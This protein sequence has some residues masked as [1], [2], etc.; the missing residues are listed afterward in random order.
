MHGH[1]S[2]LAVRRAK[3][4]PK[5]RPTD[6]PTDEQTDGQA[7]LYCRV[8]ATEIATSIFLL[9]HTTEWKHPAKDESRAGEF[10]FG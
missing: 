6:Q 5:G 1:K 8:V 9:Y 3:A 7:L 10:V 4:L 2:L